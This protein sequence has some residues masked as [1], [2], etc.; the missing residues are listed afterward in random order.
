LKPRDVKSLAVASL[1]LPVAKS[2]SQ[3]WQSWFFTALGVVCFSFTFPM[4]RLCLRTFDPILI[5]LVRG[6]G[7]GV[8]ALIVLVLSKSRTPE[9]GQLVR[10]GCAAVGMVVVFPILVSMALQSVPATHASVL[11]SILPLAT[12]VFGVVR[13]RESVS[14]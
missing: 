1:G 14:R 4:T 3:E 2:R 12:A 11:G 7:A 6:A 9:R 5:A 13:G 10:L 8:A